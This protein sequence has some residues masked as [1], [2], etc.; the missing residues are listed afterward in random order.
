MLNEIEQLEE[1]LYEMYDNGV[2]VNS[3]YFKKQSR[4]LFVIIED[5]TK[6]IN[7]LKLILS[8][9]N[10]YNLSKADMCLLQYLIDN[11]GIIRISNKELYSKLNCSSVTLYMRII[12]LESENLIRIQRY[13]STKIIYIHPEILLKWTKSNG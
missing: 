9:Y 3:K 10:S 7:M 4:Q 1:Q 13:N 12:Y 11:N 5:L 8:L 6:Q 2:N